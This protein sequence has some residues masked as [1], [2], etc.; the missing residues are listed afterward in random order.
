[1][2]INLL[3]EGL[4]ESSVASGIVTRKMLR[5]RA[6][7]LAVN[8]GRSAQEASKSDWEEAI[9]QLTGEPGP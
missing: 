4:S 2:K 9:R 5:E 6:F 7:E 1:M 8:S 3:K